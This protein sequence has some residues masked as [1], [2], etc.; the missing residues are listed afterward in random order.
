MTDRQ[1]D[2]AL[3]ASIVQSI[4]WEKLCKQN[5]NFTFSRTAKYAKFLATIFSWSANS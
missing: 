2:S 5:K 4:D 3:A 1:T